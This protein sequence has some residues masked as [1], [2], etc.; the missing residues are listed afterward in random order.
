M[1]PH[2]AT[3]AARCCARAADGYSGRA[4]KL[5][6]LYFNR[7]EARDLHPH[8]T[9]IR[10]PHL[11]PLTVRSTLSAH[12]RL[13]TLSCSLSSA[14]SAALCMVCCRH[15]GPN[16]RNQTEIKLGVWQEGRPRF[17]S[18]KGDT[19]DTLP[20]MLASSTPRASRPRCD[21][22]RLSR[23]AHSSHHICTARF[24]PCSDV[25]RVR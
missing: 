19:R 7:Y 22:R 4:V 2:A 18:Y 16:T 13:H 5:L 14:S 3:R 6:E 21:T 20:Q 15:E 10:C 12:W 9:F 8:S 11:T 24:S 17:T 23:S 1:Q 25:R